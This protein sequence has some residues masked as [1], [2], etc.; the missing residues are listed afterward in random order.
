MKEIT[1]QRKPGEAPLHR[2][3]IFDHEGYE[4][5]HVGKKATAATV[6]R[7]LGHRGAKLDEKNGRPAWLGDK[8]PPKP[9]PRM[10]AQQAQQAQPNNRTPGASQSIEI[11][12]KAAK[13]STTNKPTKPE[14]HARPHRGH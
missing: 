1:R 2:I 3:P 11:S 4:R 13:G 10:P 8:P 9:K 5:G 7:F 14:A 6:A 12:L